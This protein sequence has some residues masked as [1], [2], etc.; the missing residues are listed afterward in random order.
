MKKSIDQLFKNS[1]HEKALEVRPELWNRL[2]RRLDQDRPY[3]RQWH[4]WL[5]AASL[6]LVLT[7]TVL[8]LLNIDRYHVEDLSGEV[9]PHFSKENIAN[10]E[11]L[12]YVPPSLFLNPKY[13]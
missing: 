8:L 13:L 3:K 2:E 4:S 6:I 11:E 7:M 10:L 5:V 12:Y 1:E 9:A